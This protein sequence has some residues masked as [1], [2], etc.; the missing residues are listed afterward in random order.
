MMKG[1]GERNCGSKTADHR[2]TAM[3]HFAR[4][5]LPAWPA[6]SVEIRAGQPGG[7]TMFD[8]DATIDEEA[9]RRTA[10]FLWQ[11]DGSPPGRELDYWERAIEQH[12]RQLA[13]DK[14]LA[15]GTPDGQAEA[16]W[17]DAERKVRGY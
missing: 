1:D 16:H 17:R 8:S 12:I 10:F 9:V 14:W 4:P 15:E 2:E 13:Y 7:G 11:Q 3:E 5:R 6:G